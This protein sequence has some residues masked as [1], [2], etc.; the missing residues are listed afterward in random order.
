M[1]S[2]VTTG[3]WK[4]G[5]QPPGD[6]GFGGGRGDG[7]GGR[8]ASRR[9]SFTGLMVLLAAVVMF[10]AAMTS[11]FI[12]R[13]GLS[14]DWIHTALPS[15]IW[16]STTVLIASSIVLE[17]ARRELKAGRRAGFNRLWILGSGLG[18]LFLIGQY[19]AWLALRAQ[20]VYL[21]TNPSS[22][23]FY[24]LTAAHAVHLIGGVCALL[25]VS[26]QALRLQLGPGKRT[27]VDVSAVYWHFLDGLW[28]YLLVLFLVWG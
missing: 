17:L 14:E 22:S 11:A 9:A 19:M 27:A 2:S 23:F 3:I 25:Y 15:V 12:V 13:R 1:A 24:V 20:G 8:G 26:V 10:F 18:V 6:G 5:N 16:F 7:S 4:G 21:A 28:I